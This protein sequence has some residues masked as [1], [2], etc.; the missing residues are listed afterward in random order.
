[1]KVMS[2]WMV[3]EFLGQ[4]GAIRI[5]AAADCCVDLVDPINRPSGFADATIGIRHQIGYVILKLIHRQR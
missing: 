2:R 1:M 5:A 3:A 4:L